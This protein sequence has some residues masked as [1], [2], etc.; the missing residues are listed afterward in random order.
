MKSKGS[1]TKSWRDYQSALRRR[2]R[3][4]RAVENAPLLALLCAFCLLAILV[5]LF[6]A[7]SS[8][9]PPKGPVVAGPPA[10]SGAPPGKDPQEQDLQPPAPLFDLKGMALADVLSVEQ[11]GTRLAVET[12]IVPGLQKY[13]VKKLR[14]SMT[15]RAAAVVLDP[16]D[17][18]VLAMAG[19]NKGGDDEGLCLE[20]DFPAAS[21]FKIVSAAAALDAAGFDPHRTVSFRG[22]KHTLYKPQLKQKDGPFATKTTLA[23]AFAESVNPVF[24]KIGIYHLGAQVLEAYAR[25]FMFNR[26]I[27]FELPVGMSRVA[28]PQEAFGIAEIASGFNRQTLISPLHAALLAAAAANEGKIMAPWVV[29]KAVDPQGAIVYRGKIRPLASVVG[30]EKARDLKALMRETVVHGTCRK[31]FRP[32]RGKGKLKHVDLGAKTGSI[33]DSEDRFRYDWTVAYALPSESG[34]ALCISVLGVHGEKL[35][36]RSHD[37]ARQIIQY[38]LTAG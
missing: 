32:L 15:E 26:E 31:A 6:L 7:D 24:G 17:G 27:P 2:N 1:G 28:V 34:K 30:P 16:G 20:A 19:V 23:Q 11:G 25:K 38:Y 29:K 22:R 21:L 13:L 8:I 4:R 9:A 5:P 33:N 35:G 10:L 3:L 18:R 14:T 36:I 12:S 37:I